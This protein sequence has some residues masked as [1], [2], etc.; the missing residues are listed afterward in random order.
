MPDHL[1]CNFSQMFGLDSLEL[2]LV[3]GGC[4]QMDAQQVNI[5][6][7]GLSSPP[8]FSGK[9]SQRDTK[10]RMSKEVKDILK[11]PT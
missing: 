8:V 10:F 7:A 2:L 6:S 9:H 4:K 5:S 1:Y 3:R 11:L